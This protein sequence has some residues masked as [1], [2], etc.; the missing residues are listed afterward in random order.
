[1]KLENAMI[2][3]R[4]PEDKDAPALWALITSSP[5]LD[6]NSRYAYL[7][8]CRYFASTCVVAENEDG[9]VG[10]ITGFVAPDRPDTVFVWQVAVAKSARGTGLAQSMLDGLLK[11]DAC[12]RVRAMETTVTPSNEASRRMF[13]RFAERHGAALTE[14]RGFSASLFGEAKHEEETLLRIGPLN[15]DA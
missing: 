6:P 8:M 1:M 14:G 3:L 4:M 12:R 5:P 2:Q 13:Q 11:R 10:C 15:V 9:L 7:M